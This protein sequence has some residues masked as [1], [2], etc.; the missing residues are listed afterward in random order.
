MFTGI[1]E[2]VGTVKAI[3]LQKDGARIIIAVESI[4]AG[5]HPGDWL[6]V[7]GV[8]LTVFNIGRKELEADISSET[9]QRSTLGGKKPQDNVNLERALTPA[10]RM[11]GHIVQGHIDGTGVFQRKS[12]E[13]TGFRMFFS[14]PPAILEYV[15]EKGSIA[16]NG[17]SL[18]IAEMRPDSF[19][20]AV[21]P[22]TIEHTTLKNLHS[23]DPVNVE[24][25]ILG[26]YVYKFLQREKHEEPDRL[27]QKLQE[28][29]FMK[30]PGP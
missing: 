2:E 6:A 8:C 27:L 28:G 23:G 9:L 19:A 17:V 14:S 24:A 25:D 26:K 16:I 21:I 11:G 7:E 1:V 5:M 15:V 10:S 30:M 22:H 29:G 3:R 12:P 13:G 18:T 20:V 4:L